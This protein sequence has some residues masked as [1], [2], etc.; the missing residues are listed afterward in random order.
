MA[1]L[2]T[3]YEPPV[4]GLFC[5]SEQIGGAMDSHDRA[6]THDWSRI[7][8]NVGIFLAAIAFVVL[9]CWLATAEQKT[10]LYEADGVVC[11]SQP[12]AMQCWTR[13]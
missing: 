4:V 5:C 10:K 7:L 8:K 3:A 12:L 1:R 2:L 11:A 9:V 13:K 6:V